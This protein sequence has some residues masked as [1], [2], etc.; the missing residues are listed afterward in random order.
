MKNTL[1]H[2]NWISRMRLA[3]TSAALA[4]ATVLVPLVIATQSAQAHT[5]TVL[6]SFTGGA[7]GSSPTQGLIRDSAGNLY[8]TTGG[9]VY[10]LGVVFKVDKHGTETV[11]YSFKGGPSDGGYPESGLIRDTAGNLYGTTEYGGAGYGTVYELS[12]SGVE[13]VLYSFKGPGGDG[14]NPTGPVVRDTAGNFYGTTSAG[15]T[16]ALGTVYK[17]SATGTETIL[18]NFGNGTDG[19]EPYTGVI[20]SGTTLYG[21]TV[22]GGSF[23]VGTVWKLSAAGKETVLHNFA[24]GNSDGAYPEGSL[25]LANGNLF[26]TTFEGGL[27]TGPGIVYELS[28][29]GAETVLSNFGPDN[30]AGTYA[31]VIRDAAGNLYGTD[32]FGGAAGSGTND[33]TVYELTGIGNVSVLYS[34]CSVL[35][36]ADGGHP[37]AGL[38]RDGAGN[39]Y[40]TAETGGAYGYGTVWKLTP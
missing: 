12:A 21:N 33:G 38:L 18:H 19:A 29:L 22:A 17:L 35:N 31:G 13:T 25:L 7:D 23:G 20:R 10:G 11:L 5:L 28:L 9:G 32:A 27:Y 3:A 4:L 36:C 14:A 6:Y 16:Y 37:Y 26:G 8:G 39:F 30:G 2:R 24:G 34:F 40:G 15:G 1:Q